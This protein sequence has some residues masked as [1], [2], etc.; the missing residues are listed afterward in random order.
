MAKT[1]IKV[2]VTADRGRLATEDSGDQLAKVIM[3]ALASGDSNNPWATD[4]GTQD[5]VFG[6]PNNGT[7][8]LVERAVR[9]NFARLERDQRA[10][11]TKLAVVEAADGVLNVDVSY[12]D[13]E[14][15]TERDITT[16]VGGV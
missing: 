1:G 16:R 9:Q 2:P 3:L 11:L 8:A 10:R 7:R 14:A 4:E 6:L 12:V 5:V 13:L 15:R